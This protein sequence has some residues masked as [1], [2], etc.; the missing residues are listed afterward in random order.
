MTDAVSSTDI[1]VSAGVKK[2]ANSIFVAKLIPPPPPSV[3][4]NTIKLSFQNIFIIE[5]SW[6]LVVD[7]KQLCLDLRECWDFF[8][9]YQIK[10]GDMLNKTVFEASAL[11]AYAFYKSKCPSVCPSVCVSVHF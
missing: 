5:M 2:V 10:V 4:S 3:G 7:R 9:N 11:W 1:F 6:R 8:N